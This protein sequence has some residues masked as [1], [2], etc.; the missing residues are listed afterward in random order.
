MKKTAFFISILTLLVCIG[1]NEDY[2]F[3][4]DVAK[5]TTI[6]SNVTIRLKEKNNKPLDKIQFFINGKEITSEGNQ[7]TINTSDFG[8]GKHAVSVLAF[9]PGKT[10][11]INNSF[12]VFADT[13]YQAYTY[14]IINS[15]PHDTKAYTQGLEYYNGFLY[16]TTGRRGQSTLRK[17]EIK[18]GKVLQS[19]D[20]DKKY[21]GE[22]MTIFNNKIYWLTWES[23][24]GFVY[25]LE[26][27][28]QEES[29]DYDKSKQGWGL[30]NNDSLLIK[31]DGTSKIWF[32]DP[33]SKK[34][35]KYIQ[36]Y[37]HKQ[38]IPKLNELE[39]INGK[40]YANYYLKPLISIIN[41][42]NGVVEGIVNLSGLKK[43]MEKTQKLV[44]DDEVLNGIAFDKE[45]NRLFVTGKNWGKLFEIE[46][47]KK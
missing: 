37:T 20:L 30:T 6:N 42:K 40:I 15:Y 24:K 31:S 11:K 36:A 21:F 47:I 33:Y 43:E 17:I 16:E 26:T 9:Y 1:C 39:Y 45:N 5:K 41:P 46:L 28:E 3:T 2:K 35:I 38:S 10:K 7:I 29:F 32:L 14:K 18:T 12:E 13:P 22:G 25:N 23:K 19:V 4:L 44:A 34:E 27:F 8:V